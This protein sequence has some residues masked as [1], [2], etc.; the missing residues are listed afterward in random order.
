M[1]PGQVVVQEV[2]VIAGQTVRAALAWSSHTSGGSNTAKGDVLSADLDLRL[3]APNG[4]SA[5]SYTFD[6]SYEAVDIRI[7]ATGTLRIEIRPTR[8]D[9]SEEPFGLAWAI[10]GPFTDID[11]SPFRSDILWAATTGITAGCAPDRF[12]PGAPVTREQMA[13]FL[14][15]AD[16]LPPTSRDYF[17]DDD[18]SQHEGDINAIASARITGGCASGRYCPRNAVTRGQMASFLV[19]ALNLTPSAVD[20]FQDDEGD[21]HESAINALAAA[22]ITGGCGPSAFCPRATVTRGQM[23]AFLH[24]G[25]GP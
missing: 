12:C 10:R 18:A 8:F 4:A 13:S 6:N 17:S 20:A 1:Q 2:P 25:Y 7:G 3:V 24:R 22:G 14:R 16:S 9:A 15:R 11:A 23:A 5:G 19:R 21:L